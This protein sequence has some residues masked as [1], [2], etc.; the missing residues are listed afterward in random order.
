MFELC[1][2]VENDKDHPALYG[3]Q[4]VDP[5]CANSSWFASEQTEQDKQTLDR[6]KRSHLIF[7][8][9]ALNREKAVNDL[10]Q[11]DSAKPFCKLFYSSSPFM[12]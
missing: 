6:G 9:F 12:S 7:I 4:S 2:Y 1:V 10:T 8:S 3:I 5:F 11:R